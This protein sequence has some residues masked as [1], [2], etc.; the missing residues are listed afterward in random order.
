MVTLCGPRI[1]N[2]SVVEAVDNQP[3][4]ILQHYAL[5][6]GDRTIFISAGNMVLRDAFGLVVDSLNYGD[7]VDLWAAEGYHV[8]LGSGQSG[9]HTPAPGLM[10]GFGPFASAAPV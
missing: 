4:S 9:C 2:V 5:T 1:H 6:F 7:I 8:T 10:S 3:R